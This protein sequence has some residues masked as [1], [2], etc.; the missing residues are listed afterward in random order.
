MSLVS[1]LV[2]FVKSV[3]RKV[4]PAHRLV[5]SPDIA[6]LL[7][8]HRLVIADVGS[9]GGPEEAWLSLK[10]L[11]HFLNFEPNPR[12]GEAGTDDQTT[13]FPIGLW[14]ARG[15]RKLYLTAHPDSASLLPINTPLFADFLSKDGMEM[16]GSATIDLDTLDNLLAGKP[17]LLP[18]FL[19]IDVEG[20]E[21]EVL[22]GAR[23]ALAQS[24]LGLRVETS[25]VEMQL[26]RPLLW[27][28]DA[29]L[30]QEGFV[31]FHLG[32]NHWVRTNRLH[33]FSSAPQLIWGDAVYFLTRESFIKRLAACKE[34]ER[35]ALLA[36]FIVILVRY[37]IHDYAW[38]II[39]AAHTA[40]LVPDA[41]ADQLKVLVSK[42]LDTSVWYLVKGC[43]GVGFA[44]LVLLCSFPLPEP[45]KR[46]VFYLK[47][48][49]GRL[50][51]D[52]W[53]LTALSGRAPNA[54]VSDPFV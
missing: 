31:L 50:F 42:S 25:F 45:R 4:W 30:R 33:G 3:D 1:K 54:C 8:Q 34:T 11:V 5:L 26:G 17:E 32:R 18:D 53:R 20:G 43:L 7:R 16:V 49:A 40:K 38:D 13:N 23:Q 28:V 46:G 41:F 19:K 48:R 22:K 15:K 36:K 2:E 14:S 24:I 39:E 10:E 44:L 35:T 9:A 27:E 47:Q 37:G 6:A 29:F 21:L 12:P 51:Y 52:L